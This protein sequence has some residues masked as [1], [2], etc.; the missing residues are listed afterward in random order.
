MLEVGTELMCVVAA[1][2]LVLS[3]GSVLV[4]LLAAGAVSVV[5]VPR[6]AEDAELPSVEAMAVGL[7]EASGAGED[8][9][10]L[11]AGDRLMVSAEDSGAVLRSMVVGPLVPG[12]EAG[13]LPSGLPNTEAVVVATA[14]EE[15]P[16]IAEVTHAVVLTTGVGTCE[17]DAGRLLTGM[18]LA[19]RLAEAGPG[20]LVVARGRVE[21]GLEVD[22][23]LVGVV[24]AERLVLSTG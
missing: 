24:A 17:L 14:A 10:S 5:L 19:E 11:G 21:P 4:A 18:V 8:A 12:T 1:E 6:V 22:T 3:T 13:V 15:D 23:G 16:P 7:L 9:A 20:S 2:K